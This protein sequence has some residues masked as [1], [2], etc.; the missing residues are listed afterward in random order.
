MYEIF[1]ALCKSHGVTAYKVSQETGIS[2]STFTCWKK[3][4]YVPKTDK[5][6]II[7]NYFGVTEEYLRTGKDTR[8]ETSNADLI[9]DVIGDMKLMEALKKYM[10]LS[11]EKKNHVL[12]MIN[13]LSVE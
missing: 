6:A 1:E 8:Y 9:A 2:T 7:A 3:G 4:K 12:E 11:D 13:L 10:G 5:M